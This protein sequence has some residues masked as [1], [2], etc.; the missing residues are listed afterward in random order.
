MRSRPTW[1]TL[2][3]LWRILPIVSVLLIAGI[4]VNCSAGIPRAQLNRCN[5]GVADGNDAFPVRQGPA[6]RMIAQRLAADDKVS[7]AMGYARKA[8][9]LE[10]GPGCEYYLALVRAQSSLQPD[11]LSQARQ[12]GEMACSGMVVSPDGAD[13]R[14]I[15]CAR[16][17]DLY[18]DVEPRSPGDA[19]RMYVRACKLGD[20]KS[21]ARARSLGATLEEPMAVS[22][23]PPAPA[24]A[25]HAPQAP[26]LARPI[27][28]TTPAS[29]L[30]G[31]MPPPCHEMKQCVAL[32]VNQRNV[33]E[34]V[35][36]L[37]N[38][39]DRPVACTWCPARNGQV[40]KTGCHNAQLAPNES[41]GGREE[42]LWYDGFNAI[43]YDCTEVNDAKRCLAL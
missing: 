28:D 15:I 25:R 12:A 43:A 14:P 2:P 13:A 31:P 37:V 30:T 42:G 29:A 26:Q 22:A 32:E 34:V 21:C 19:A 9:M 3:A 33:T 20:D 8:C 5:L 1:S 18:Q 27:A 39:C 4:G 11:E 40:E 17:G 24:A 23:T 16:T 7:E 36:T 38:H 6:C 35:G 10:D 41:R